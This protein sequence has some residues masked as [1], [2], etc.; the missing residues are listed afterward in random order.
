MANI[1]STQ[2]DD[3]IPTLVAAEALGYLK[4]NTVL[5]RLV[6]R[7]WENEYAQGGQ[8]VQI[9]FTGTLSANAKA[10]GSTVTLQQPADSKISVTL[11]K[12]KEVSFLLE[13]FGRVLA[14]P[15]YLNAYIADAMAVIAEKIDADLAGLYSGLSQTIAALT[16]N[17]GLK[18]SD[19]RNA[20]RLL[21]AA[22]A[23]LTDRVAVLNEDADYEFLGIE[24]ALNRDYAQTLGQAAADS[25]I[26]RFMGFNVFM[27]QKIVTTGS[28]NKNLF[29][30]RNAFVL[31]MRPLPPAP[32]GAGVIQK[33]MDED[34][35][36]LRVTMSYNPDYLGVQVTIDVLYGVAE[37]RDAFGVV[38]STTD[39]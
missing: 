9:P 19:F 28:Q 32:V 18:E 26:G 22:K 34:G 20:R 15:D 37:L 24:K 27:D 2:L 29:M 8:T 17:G 11:D 21:N 31:A 6:A 10:E 12:H 36:G 16:A 30:H 14:R 5:A 39:Q 35:M 13:D 4:A 1:T 23:P 33:T 25:H 3:S 7:N 38:V